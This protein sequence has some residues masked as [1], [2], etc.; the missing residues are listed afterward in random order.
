M[1]FKIIRDDITKVKADAIVNPVNLEV[2][3]GGGVE[4]AIYKAAA[5]ISKQYFSKLLKWQV[6][7]SKE[8]MLALAVGLR[9]NMDETVDFLRIAGY[10][11]SPI[12]QT[13]TVVEYFIRKQEYNVLK[14]DIVL[15][16]YGLEPLSNI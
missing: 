1:P 13:D 11:L 6:K 12:S 10:A 8:K 4:S 15:F 5:N 3:I 9:L 16:D 2:C 14:I 7:P